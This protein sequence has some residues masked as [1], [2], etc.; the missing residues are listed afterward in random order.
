MAC[1]RLFDGLLLHW[2]ERRERH[3]GGIARGIG[4]CHQMAVR[5]YQQRNRNRGWVRGTC[6]DI[7]SEGMILLALRE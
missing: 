7:E 2:Q 4:T 6:R 1:Q 5:G 3:P